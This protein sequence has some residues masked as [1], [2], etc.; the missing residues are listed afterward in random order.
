[1]F[2]QWMKYS[3]QK[4]RADTCVTCYN[5]QRLPQVKPVP[6]EESC[7]QD[8]HDTSRLCFPHCVMLEAGGQLAQLTSQTA[9]E[10]LCP[11]LRLNVTQRQEEDL[12]PPIVQVPDD[13]ESH[14]AW[15]EVQR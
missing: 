15:L 9:K 2:Y 1:M 11:D 14:S 7:L 5:R 8:Q 12:A 6:D 13:I 4:V 10:R 3:S